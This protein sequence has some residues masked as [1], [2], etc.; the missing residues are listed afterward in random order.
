MDVKTSP[1][2]HLLRVLP[3]DVHIHPPWRYSISSGCEWKRGVARIGMGVDVELE[4]LLLAL[5][6][7]LFTLVLSLVGL[8]PIT[9]VLDAPTHPATRLLVLALATF[10]LQGPTPTV[11]LVP[12]ATRMVRIPARAEP[13]F[14]RVV[15][16]TVLVAVTALGAF[17]PCWQALLSSLLPRGHCSVE[18]GARSEGYWETYKLAQDD[19]WTAAGPSPGHKEDF[20]P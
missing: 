14:V 17:A 20:P 11:D 3:V 9:C 16:L 5:L 15:P 4:T 18:T 2:P 10:M 13:F 7:K 6:L 12:D 8:R 1:R 19:G